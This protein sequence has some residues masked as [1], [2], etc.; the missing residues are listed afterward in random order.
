MLPRAQPDRQ[1]ARY[2]TWNVAR[3]STTYA[4]AA[5]LNVVTASQAPAVL[6]FASGT[7]CDAA[8]P[9]MRGLTVTA[10]V[11]PPGTPDVA[12]ATV[13][14][15]GAANTMSTLPN[16]PSGTAGTAAPPTEVIVTVGLT[17]LASGV[18]PTIRS[19]A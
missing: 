6:Q 9:P 1:N 2:C 8:A 15:P 16:V 3:A 12:T 13:V 17:G 4:P 19:V 5:R 18:G 7:V 10:T 11:V 14:A